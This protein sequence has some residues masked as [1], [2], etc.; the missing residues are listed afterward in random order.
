MDD[1][2]SLPNFFVMGFAHN[3][4]KKVIQVKVGH[5]EGDV[6]GYYN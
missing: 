1:G 3:V 4:R 5:N 6:V 2:L